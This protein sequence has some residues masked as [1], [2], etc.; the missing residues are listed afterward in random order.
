MSNHQN[1]YRTIA[2]Q[3]GL[4]TDIRNLQNI[5]ERNKWQ[6]LIEMKYWG[7]WATQLVK[8]QTRFSSGHDLIVVNSSPELGF[9][10]IAWDLLSI[11]SPSLSAP[12]PLALYFSLKINK[13]LKNEVL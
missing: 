8:Q 9:A 1:T 13:N 7:A 3:L 5:E 4:R 11:V 2:E 12:P 10:L 6:L